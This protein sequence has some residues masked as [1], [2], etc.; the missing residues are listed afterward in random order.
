MQEMASLLRSGGVA[1]TEGR[2][3]LR[4]T[5]FDHFV[6]QQYGGDI[7]DPHIDF[8]HYSLDEMLRDAG[9]IST[10]FTNADLRHRFEIYND[11]EEMIG[12][13]HHDWPDEPV[14]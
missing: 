14:A 3:S 7:G 12:Y 9:R 8:E 5:D 4:L 13:L 2:Y 10:I 1:V 11:S 6:L